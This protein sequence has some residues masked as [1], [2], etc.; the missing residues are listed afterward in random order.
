MKRLPTP[1]KLASSCID[2]RNRTRIDGSAD[3]LKR[4]EQEAFWFR[5]PGSILSEHERRV[6]GSLYV[7]NSERAVWRCVYSEVLQNIEC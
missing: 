5:V 4:L 6:L 1:S 3:R 2:T 7:I